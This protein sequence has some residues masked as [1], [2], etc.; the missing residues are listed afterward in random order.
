MADYV[1][2]TCP[3]C[4]GKLNITSDI[5]RFACGHCGNEHIV[6]R[7]GGIV[8][9]APVIEHLIQVKNGVDKTASELAIKRLQEEIFT[10]ES[11]R[12]NIKARHENERK[13][14]SQYY[15]D[16]SNEIR[17]VGEEK[18][19]HITKAILFAISAIGIFIL[20]MQSQVLIC[21]FIA[22]IPLMISG[23]YALRFMGAHDHISQL[24]ASLSSIGES[25][26][27]KLASLKAKQQAEI[28][29]LNNELSELNA[30]LLQHRRI[31]SNQ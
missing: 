6:K 8:S 23:V 27:R 29:Q 7:G 10:L 13:N 21:Y 19:S 15:Y 3:S 9:L 2:L 31:V 26:D 18:Q 1:S 25:N 22:V 16:K 14:V 5:E 4:G 30:Q 11:Q 17:I 12:A 28:N 24:E 20:A